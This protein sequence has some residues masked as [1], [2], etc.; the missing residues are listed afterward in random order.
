MFRNRKYYNVDFTELN[1]R[2]RRQFE[3]NINYR[4]LLLLVFVAAIIILYVGPYIFSWLFG[5]TEESRGTYDDVSYVCLWQRRRRHLCANMC[6]CHTVL[7]DLV[8]TKTEEYRNSLFALL[9][10]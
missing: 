2:L 1:R 10:L 4:R 7:N 6:M 5:A 9:F 3:G 8:I